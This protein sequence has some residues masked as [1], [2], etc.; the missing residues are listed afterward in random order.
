MSSSYVASEMISAML[1]NLL[2]ASSLAATCFSC[3]MVNS[4]CVIDFCVI[5]I[6]REKVGYTPNPIPTGR[7]TPLESTQQKLLQ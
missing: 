4:F 3:F 1:S 7:P 5:V 2:S 6:S